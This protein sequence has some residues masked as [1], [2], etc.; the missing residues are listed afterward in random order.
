LKRLW[1][2]GCL[3][4]PLGSTRLGAEIA[5]LTNGSTFKLTSHRR[6]GELVLLA[7]KGGGEVGVTP[8]SIRAIV[9]DEIEEEQTPTGD[10]RDLRTLVAET[11]KKHH[12]DPDLIW[13]IIAAE[14]AF[15]PSAVSPKGAQ[16]LMQLMPATSAAL[17]VS[18]PFDPGANLEGGSRLLRS[19]MSY[20]G[21]N[22]EKA[23]AAYNAGAEAV[24]RYKGVPPYKETQ[25]Y[26][27]QI[28]AQYRGKR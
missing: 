13:A 4:L 21:G 7:L 26:V 17:Q 11:A 16:G 22:L 18:N 28:L 14:S 9:P 10:S 23:L 12:L 15:N 20:Y 5:V 6:E 25:L 27:R 1:L 3:V 19:L 2:I 8:A 24:K